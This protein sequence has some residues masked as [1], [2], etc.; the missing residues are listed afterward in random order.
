MYLW[1]RQM[2]WC[3]NIIMLINETHN[4]IYEWISSIWARCRFVLNDVHNVN[5]EHSLYFPRSLLI[6]MISIIRHKASMAVAYAERLSST[7]TRQCVN[8]VWKIVKCVYHFTST[9]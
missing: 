1:E 4:I 5:L 7:N 3:P 9:R 6:D 8:R 2:I